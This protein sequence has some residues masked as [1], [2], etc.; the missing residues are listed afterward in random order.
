MPPMKH[1]HGPK[2]KTPGKTLLRL[3]GYLKK[4]AFSLIVVA[5]CIFISAFASTKGSEKYFFATYIKSDTKAKCCKK[6]YKCNPNNHFKFLQSLI[7][8]N[9]IL[10]QYLQQ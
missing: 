6:R 3:L 9:L 10:H 2:A 8:R 1:A 7:S 5:V 4:Y